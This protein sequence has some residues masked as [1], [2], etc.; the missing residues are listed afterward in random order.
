[1][2]RGASIAISSAFSL[3]PS[4]PDPE[5]IDGFEFGVTLNNGGDPDSIR[6]PRKFGDVIDVSTN[7]V[8]L[9]MPSGATG[10]W[11]A[12]LHFDR[13]GTPYLDSGWRR[14]CQQHEIVAGH[15][16]VF[17]YDDD[18]QITVTVFDETMCRRHNIAPARGKAAISSSSEDNE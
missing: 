6:L 12:E 11:I 3:S 15:F 7:Q 2:D 1:L 14:F 18:H 4:T 13:T 10:L 8:L 5:P 17:N 9:R 16:V